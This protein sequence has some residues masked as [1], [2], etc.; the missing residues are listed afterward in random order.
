[1]AKKEGQSD[2]QSYENINSLICDHTNKL[3]EAIESIEQRLLATKEVKNDSRAHEIICETEMNILN[4]ACEYFPKAYEEWK[5]TRYENIESLQVIANNLED[6]GGLCR[7]II[8]LLLGFILYIA[9]VIITVIL[10]RKY[11]L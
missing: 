4:D 1:M 11:K 8:E 3:N 7:L 6:V 2:G 10:A 5:T 9:G